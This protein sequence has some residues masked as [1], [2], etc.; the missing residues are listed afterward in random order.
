MRFCS[1]GSGS[2]GNASLVEASQ[3]ITSTLLL[4][5]CGFSQRE[6]LRR[7]ARAGLGIE[8][9]NGVF[10][11]HEHGDHVGCALGLCQRY[12]IPLWT[13]RGTWRAISHRPGAENFDKE[14]L[15][16]L[17][18]DGEVVELGD[19]RLHPF[20]V[21]HDAAEPLQLICEDGRHRLGLLTDVGSA[22]A[23]LIER[24]CGLDG[25][26]L[27]CNH[28]EEMLRNGPYPASLKRRILGSHGH[29]SNALAAEILAQCGHADLQWVAAAHL[30]ERNNL[31]ALAFRA[32]ADAL[33]D[34]AP[35][36]I[37]VADQL[38]GLGWQVLR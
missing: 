8:A 9:L 21:P 19:L 32:L 17:V 15:L 2:A 28:D 6:L 13:S 33:G 1:L 38:L 24:L 37:L 16:H 27:E 23:A 25:L 7:L 22:P 4:V 20:A 30:S 26:L 29:L 18:R 11:T 36:R 14:A 35:E 12:R 34:S 5:D 3:G 31:P 10:I